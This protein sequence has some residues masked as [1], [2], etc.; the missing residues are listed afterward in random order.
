MEVGSYYEQSGN[1]GPPFGVGNNKRSGVE[2]SV[3]SV[4]EN[5]A[6][7]IMLLSAACFFSLCGESSKQTRDRRGQAGRLTHGQKEESCVR[8]RSKQ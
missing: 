3:V 7:V 4:A 2:E 5:R 8:S 6:I 1:L